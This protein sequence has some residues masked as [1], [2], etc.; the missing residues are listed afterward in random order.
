MAEWRYSS[1]F[2]TLAV[3]GG[4]GLMII[5]LNESYINIKMNLLHAQ[6]NARPQMK[7]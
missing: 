3:D 6:P 2:L 5:F 1:I 4:E 7:P